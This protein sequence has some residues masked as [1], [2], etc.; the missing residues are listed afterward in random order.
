MSLDTVERPVRT[1]EAPATTSHRPVAIFARTRSAAAVRNGI[2]ILAALAA[3]GLPWLG[4]NLSPSLSAWHLHLSLGAV[5]LV[6][7]ITYGMVVG[8]LTVGAG[9][10]LVRSGGWATTVSRAVGWVF[11]ALS[12]VFVVTTRMVGG[13]TMFALESD[14]SQS[15]IIN[16]QFLTN[17]STP[18]PTQFLGISF[19]SKTLVLLYALRTGWYFLLVAGIV[20]AGRLRR[21]D[22]RPQRVAAWTAAVAALVVVVGLVLGSVAQSD[23]DDGIQAV[24]TGRPVAGQQLLASAVRLNPQIAYDSGLQQARGQAQADQG[25]MSGLADYA[26]AVR[27]G[28]V[29]LTLLQQAQLFQRALAEVPAGTVAGDVLRADVVGFLTNATVTAKNP[30]LL[31]L[32][33]GELS[34]PAVAFSVGR[35]YYEAGAASLAIAT[36]DRAYASTDN[37]EVRSLALTY[38]ALSWLRLGDEAKFR[39]S[40][41]AA[42]A[43]DVLNENVYARELSTGLYVPGTP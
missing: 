24:A 38:I 28:G 15:H 30:D 17:N 12:V 40:I 20:L 5:P 21:P 37:S 22:T 39:H 41:V 19:D 14:A 10:S 42:V 9:V 36:L 23:L 4:L 1:D 33:A 32:V 8:V 16:T 7:W 18:A 6:H 25:N 26:E 3:L 27:P 13:A 43:A 34:S 29:D 35:Y 2:G 11:I 31:N